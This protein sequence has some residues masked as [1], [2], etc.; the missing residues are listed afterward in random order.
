MHQKPIKLGGSLSSGRAVR[1]RSLFER[2][3]NNKIAVIALEQDGDYG[4][5]VKVSAKVDL[6]GM[7]QRTLRFY[8]YNAQTGKFIFINPQPRFYVDE[9]GFLNFDTFFAG[10]II[11]TDAALR[12]K[13]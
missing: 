4:K 12:K 7:N 10:D 5:T 9:K 3:Y 13:E 2:Y 11:I 8:S 6:R 1:T